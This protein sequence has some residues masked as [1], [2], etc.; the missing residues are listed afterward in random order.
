MAFFAALMSSKILDVIS[1]HVYIV[2]AVL[3]ITGRR[4][5]PWFAP[6]SLIYTTSSQ[7]NQS[8]PV[9]GFWVDPEILEDL[10]D[11]LFFSWKSR[12]CRID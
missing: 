11:L 10:G 3:S 2:S 1:A 12:R 5:R 7:Q 8:P 6:S 9:A 4:S